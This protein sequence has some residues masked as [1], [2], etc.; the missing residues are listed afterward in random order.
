MF[1][2]KYI[3]KLARGFKLR[4]VFEEID[5]TRDE[6]LNQTIP[7]IGSVLEASQRDG[8]KSE[9][10]RL[11]QDL[12]TRQL[13]NYRGKNI[14]E[15]IRVTLDNCIHIL[16]VVQDL[17]EKEFQE[18]ITPEGLSLRNAHTL[19]LLDGI[20]MY[21]KYARRLADAVLIAEEKTGKDSDGSELDTLTQADLDYLTENRT[22]FITLTDTLA[23]P[24]KT[25]EEMYK[26]IPDVVV[27][28]VRSDAALAVHGKDKVDP[29][30]FGFYEARFNP[31]WLLATN[32]AERQAKRYQE[33]KQDAELLALRI[34][35]YKRMNE[36][37]NDPKMEQI[38]RNREKEL[39][40]V[41]AKLYKMENIR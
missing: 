38:I 2:T 11:H 4:R 16:T 14:F 40:L 25:I 27:S 37:K 13:K 17:A 24:A 35:R 33:A 5:V 19:Q 22:A 9:T 18:D 6:L 34:Q 12:F 31:I 15:P 7:I 39:D 30:R 28:E 21:T 8:F 10:Y 23:T 3:K 41:R 32:G 26:L 29:L 1:V 20:A 36:G